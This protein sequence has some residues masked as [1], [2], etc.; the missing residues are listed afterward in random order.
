M[1]GD[2]RLPIQGPGLSDTGQSEKLLLFLYPTLCCELPSLHY[3][4]TS[5]PNFVHPAPGLSTT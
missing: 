5:G 4:R 1:R 3:V 2:W